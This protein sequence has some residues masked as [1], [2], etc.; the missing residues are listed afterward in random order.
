MK[1]LGRFLMKIIGWKLVGSY[2]PEIKKCVILAAPHTSNWDFVIGRFAYWALDVPVKFLIKKE[3]FDHPLGWAIVKMGGIPVDRNKNN[4]L[5]GSVAEIFDEYDELNVIVT[6]EGTRKLAMEWKRGYYYI[7]QM[8]EVPIVMGFVDYK[9]KEGGFGPVLYPTGD[10]DKD[11]EFIKSFYKEKTARY[12]ENFSLSPI[13]LNE[14][15]D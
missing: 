11:F 5:V 4:N 2:P 6:P 3:A 7:A 8:A 15:I 1:L 14:E 13:Y 12:P 10:Y 9:K